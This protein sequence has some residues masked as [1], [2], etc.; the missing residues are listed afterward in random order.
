MQSQH[1]FCFCGGN[2]T[3]ADTD[4]FIFSVCTPL[5][6]L[7]LQ[8]RRYMPDRGAMLSLQNPNTFFN[9]II[10]NPWGWRGAHWRE[11]AGGLDACRGRGMGVRCRITKS[12][13]R[14]WKVSTASEIAWTKG[15][16]MQSGLHVRANCGRCW[17]CAPQHCSFCNPQQSSKP[18]RLN[19][20]L[21]LWWHK[22]YAKKLL[23]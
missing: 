14:M 15:S 17:T 23:F 11:G 20:P 12:A 3:M 21:S 13:Q 10:W 8:N 9:I 16:G 1:F 5:S 22:L 18:L 7:L 2:H 4:C 6:R 19:P